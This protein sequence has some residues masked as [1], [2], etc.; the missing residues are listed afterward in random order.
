MKAR[1]KKIVA[2]SAA[3]LI[4]VRLPT[5]CAVILDPALVSGGT[6]G[7]GAVGGGAVGG[8]GGVVSLPPP[9]G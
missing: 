6:A 3:A 1:S 9:F 2:T 8:G 5:G 4:A 7:G